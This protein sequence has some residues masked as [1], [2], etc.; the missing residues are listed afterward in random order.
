MQ[1]VKIKEQSQVAKL[2]AWKLKSKNAAIVFGNT[3]HLYGVSR[4]EFLADEKWIRHELKHVLQY[5]QYGFAAFIVKYL[6]E[7]IKKGYYNNRFETEARKSEEDEMITKEFKF[8]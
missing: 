2:A 5:K 3:I 8:Y 1:K 6:F 4:E 7:G